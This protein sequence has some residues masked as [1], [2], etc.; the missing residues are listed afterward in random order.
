M[1]I[2]PLWGTLTIA[3]LATLLLLTGWV[4]ADVV[5]LLTA[6]LLALF[7]LI[8]PGQVLSGLSNPAVVVI[9]CV[10]ILTKGLETSGLTERLGKQLEKAAGQSEGRFLT[11]VMLAAALLSLFMN[12]IAAAA[13]LLPPLVA[14]TRRERAFSLR[15]ALMPMA[16]GTLLGGTATLL[17]TANLVT[18]AALEAHGYRGYGLLDFLP[19]GLPVTVAGVGFML[20]IGR[21]LLPAP[22]N[23]SPR[24][25]PGEVLND[26]EQAY[27]LASEL[28]EIQVQADSP[29][30]GRVAQR[31]R[32]ARDMGITPL[33]M[34][35]DGEL[36]LADN[37]PAGRLVQAGDIWLV[38]GKTSPE[39][40][41][42][43]GL[44]T[45]DSSERELLGM[46]DAVLAEVTPNPR[47]AAIG[48]TPQAL[49]LR[50]TFGI[51]VLLVWRHG[52]VIAH[53]VHETPLQPGD[54]L[55]VYGA[56]DSLRRMCEDGAFAI[57]SRVGFTGRQETRTVR[58]ALLAMLIALLPAALNYLPL[59]LSALLGVLVLLF[60]NVLTPEQAYQ[61][62]SWRV[63]F[64]IAGM[65]PLA[66]AMQQS[67]AAAFL[68]GHLLSWM[69]P[70]APSWAVAGVFAGITIGMAQVVSG[71]A[72]ALIL[73]PLAIAA[74][75]QYHLDPRALAMAVAVPASLGFLLPTAHPVNL[76]VMGPADYHPRDYLKVGLPLTLLLI[77]VILIAI[78]LFWL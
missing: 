71:Q 2:S 4:R 75:G 5:G 7:G 33:G 23:P 35:L 12:T 1:D 37:L 46:E 48:A 40:L 36:V 39:S 32:M 76:L 60:A 8:P 73:A 31:P 63:I 30:I 20:T 70:G 44:K 68:S 14:V 61:A 55:L 51:R 59:A 74:A 47:G 10:F 25:L 57:L 29:L 54:A 34:L 27:H 15:R 69:G 38:V 66:Q 24:P 28:H 53:R 19:V 58:W 62:V 13:V 22:E 17:T 3:G 49:H 43:L 72:A 9:L 6:A 41:E 50:S 67:G 42:Q 45:L 52:R 26:L 16:F 56:R 11:A 78:R 77:P 18:S 64:L 21:K 65:I